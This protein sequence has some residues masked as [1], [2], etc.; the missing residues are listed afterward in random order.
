MLSYE[1]TDYEFAAIAGDP[2]NEHGA[3]LKFVDAD[4]ISSD[5]LKNVWEKLSH[6][7][8]NHHK[9]CLDEANCPSWTIH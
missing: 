9:A 1:T 2:G 8:R 5:Y 3:I 6:A 7:V 4:D